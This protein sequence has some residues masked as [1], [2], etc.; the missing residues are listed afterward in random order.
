MTDDFTPDLW[1]IGHSNHPIEHVLDLLCR[2]GI[3]AVVDVRSR[4][5]SR[6]APQYRKDRLERS[7]PDAG[8]AYLHLGNELGGKPVR[9]DEPKAGLDYRSR[10]VRPDF[11]RSIERLLALAGERR[12]ALMCRERDPL[13]CHRTHLICRHLRRRVGAIRHILP[14]GRLEA[15]SATEQRLLERV[16][17]DPLPLFDGAPATNED[18][19]E[20]AYDRFWQYGA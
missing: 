3:E 18:A 9:D 1:T 17:V 19:L 13:D 16:G 20:R 12:T 5:Y 10:I 2:H 7:M 4:P 6:F 15:H 8:I 11:R 14:D